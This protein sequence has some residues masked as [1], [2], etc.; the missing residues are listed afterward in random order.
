MRPEIEYVQTQGKSCLDKYGEK[1][2]KM[3]ELKMILVNVNINWEF[4]ETWLKNRENELNGAQ[5]KNIDKLLADIQAMIDWLGGLKDVLSKNQVKSLI[6][7]SP[8]IDIINVSVAVE[9]RPL[10]YF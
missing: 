9:N 5:Q 4:I 6:N 8:I 1:D 7:L 2:P 10:L 3:K